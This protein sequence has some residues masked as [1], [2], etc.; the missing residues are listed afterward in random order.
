MKKIILNFKGKYQNFLN[1][2]IFKEICVLIE[3]NKNI[4]KKV[5]DRLLALSI[6]LETVEK[7]LERY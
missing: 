6:Y 7:S 5:N 1:E 3:R 4:R 2:N